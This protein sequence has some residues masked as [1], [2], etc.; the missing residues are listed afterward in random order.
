MA[1]DEQM[2]RLK[3]FA[4]GD[5]DL[6]R[7]ERARRQRAGKEE[8]ELAQTR[9]ATVELA[10]VGGQAALRGIHTSARRIQRRGR[11]C[12]QRRSTCDRGR[13]LSAGE[14]CAISW[15]VGQELIEGSLRKLCKIAQLL[16][17]SAH[18]VVGG[19]DAGCS[20]G[21]GG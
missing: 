18:R 3:H 11:R 15:R 13:R 4:L 21:G 16:E 12:P 20:G 6:T 5:Q 9:A 10:V 19:A 8:E 14:G 7:S 1:T 17:P 2:H